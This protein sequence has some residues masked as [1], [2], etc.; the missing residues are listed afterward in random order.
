MTVTDL[1]PA[2]AFALYFRADQ[3]ISGGTQQRFATIVSIAVEICT[4]VLLPSNNLRPLRKEMEQ[5]IDLPGFPAIIGG[6]E[7]PAAS[8]PTKPAPVYRSN[9]PNSFCSLPLFSHEFSHGH[10]IQTSF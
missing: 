6:R 10:S 9:S 7:P 2:L 8:P 4:V 5:S 3:P 1:L